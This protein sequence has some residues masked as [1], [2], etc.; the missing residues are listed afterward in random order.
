MTLNHLAKI[1]ATQCPLL[2]HAVRMRDLDLTD[3]LFY[4]KR[5]EKN[6]YSEQETAETLDTVFQLQETLKKGNEL[7]QIAKIKSYTEYRLLQKLLEAI[8]SLSKEIP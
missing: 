1:T 4:L 2:Y 5:L 7:E 3:M 8:P 6:G